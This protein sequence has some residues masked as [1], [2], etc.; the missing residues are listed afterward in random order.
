MYMT[1]AIW[2][3]KGA[4]AAIFAFTGISKMFLSKAKLLAKG[5]KG[6]TDLDENQIKVVGLL[7]DL[8]A[9]GLILPTLLNMGPIITVISAL[10]LSLTMIVAGWINHKLRLSI[11]PNI[12]IFIICILIAYLELK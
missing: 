9:F 3:L 5:M 7:E 2:I 11:I 10:C 1:T 12:V 4:I 6:L 8:G